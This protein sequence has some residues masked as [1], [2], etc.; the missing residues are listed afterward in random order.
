MP[1]KICFNLITL[2]LFLDISRTT[3]ILTQVILVFVS[4]LFLVLFII[5]K[6]PIG[7]F[8]VILA[9]TWI[10]INILAVIFLGNKFQLSAVI[11]LTANF[12]LLPYMLT[13]YYGK[14]LF[15]KL[16][17][18]FYILTFVSLPLFALNLIFKPFF[19]S[20]APSLA[21]FTN[22]NL[23]GN[24]NY[25][26]CGFYVNAV[27][28][29]AGGLISYLRNSGFMWE[30][31]YFA[32]ICTWSIIYN[33]LL[34]GVKF[35]KRFVV[36]SLAI[37]TTY[38]TAG[39]LS[40][41]VFAV[42]FFTKKISLSRVMLLIPVVL[43]FVYYIYQL[44]FMGNK[45]DSYIEYAEYNR[46]RYD[47]NYD[48]VKLNRFEIAAYDIKRVVKYPLGFGYYDR[49]SFD[50]VDVVGTNGLS[51]LLRMW[52]VPVF[53][54]MIVCVYRFFKVLNLNNN[55]RRVILLLFGALL[56]NFFSQNIQYNMLTYL[57]IMSSVTLKSR[58]VY[59][60]QA[61]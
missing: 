15:T 22:P 44:D 32:L 4:L 54:I 48:A 21:W 24:P 57:I 39:Y 40:L 2:L 30:P 7:K 51:G 9:I 56:I 27:P 12:I 23:I 36:Y 26:S 37:L 34:Y 13:T 5:E 45:I 19:D 60:R 49:T 58:E 14:N 18:I 53:I 20:F 46:F 42:I 11:R 3:S 38:S 61:V 6:K 10:L 31:G 43:F 47:A 41:F 50:G 25:W 16:E 59:A 33:W 8:P 29:I 17:S 55:N 1:Q 35:N 28:E 52:G